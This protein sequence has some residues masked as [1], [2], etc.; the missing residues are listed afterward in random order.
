MSA[1][2][3]GLQAKPAAPY[4]NGLMSV[5]DLMQRAQMAA[6]A[7]ERGDVEEAERLAP[8]LM[9]ALS[10][11]QSAQASPTAPQKKL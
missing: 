11:A 10:H 9:A 2:A 8:S 4:V 5:L 6:D 1:M 3:A 7:L